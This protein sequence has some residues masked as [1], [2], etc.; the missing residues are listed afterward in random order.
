MSTTQITGVHLEIT[1][2]IREHVEGKM[3]KIA[4]HFE[5]ITKAHFMLKVDKKNHIA[6]ATIHASGGADLFAEA[7]AANMYA[8]I[9]ELYDKLNRQVLKHKDK[10]IRK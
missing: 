4:H 10:M 3:S 7:T 2:P 1:P 5:H 9:D 6:E 8:A